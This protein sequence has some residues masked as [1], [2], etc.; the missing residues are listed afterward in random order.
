MAEEV[1]MKVHDI[2][3]LQ[4]HGQQLPHGWQARCMD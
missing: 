1:N 3:G 4:A 2:Q